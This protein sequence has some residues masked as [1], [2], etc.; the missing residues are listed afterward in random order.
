MTEFS[1]L[2]SAGLAGVAVVLAA[3]LTFVILI[4]KWVNAKY[5]NITLLLIRQLIYMQVNTVTIRVTKLMLNPMFVRR[6][7]CIGLF[8]VHH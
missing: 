5:Q 7:Y 6:P 2:H 3:D 4:Y 8:L 1:R